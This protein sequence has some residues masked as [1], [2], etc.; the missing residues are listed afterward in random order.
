MLNMTSLSTNLKCEPQL[1]VFL[2][3]DLHSET[4][5]KK[6]VNML[7]KYKLTVSYEKVLSMEVCFAQAIAQQTRKNADIVCPT[8]LRRQIFTVAALDNLDHNP[9]SRT[10][11][12]SFH[13][14]G[15][16]LFQ[17]PTS[18]KPGLHQ[19]C[20][21]INSKKPGESSIVGPILPHSYTSV[22][23]VGLNLVTQPPVKV[24]QPVVRGSFDAERQHEEAWMKAVN[25]ILYVNSDL[26]SGTPTMWSSFHA[27]RSDVVG[28]P[29]KSIE[30]LLPLFHDKAETPEMIHHGMNLVKKN[31]EHL[32][33]Q[34][35]PV[36]VV[37]QPLYDLAKKMQWTFP[38]I[39]RRRQVCGDVRWAPH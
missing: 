18:E 22:P 1:A 31:T 8:N 2:A 34:Q 21:K 3:L 30:A 7:H 33:P 27:A 38:D 17:F 9:T 15:I 39:F 26:E 29:E 13:G 20:L 4:R 16:S 12:S 37:D 19:E 24:V 36:M 35:V 23:P 11:S 28:Q 10:A 6:L 5:S 25:D 32:N 14:T